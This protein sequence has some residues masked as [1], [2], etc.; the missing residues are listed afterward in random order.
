MAGLGH[1][2]FR[3]LKNTTSQSPLSAANLSNRGAL[4]GLGW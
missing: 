1:D 2:S 3:F 4:L